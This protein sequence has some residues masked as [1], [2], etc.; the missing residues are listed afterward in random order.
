MPAD[1]DP[2][3][4]SAN[5]RWKPALGLLTGLLWLALAAAL[6]VIGAQADLARPNLASRD[7]LLLAGSIIVQVAAPL[8]VILV[9]LVLLRRTGRDEVALITALETR[10]A[11]AIAASNG[12]RNGLNEIDRGLTAI[13]ARLELLQSTANSEGAGLVDAATRLDAAATAMTTAGREA[14]QQAT[15]L[16]TLIPDAGKQA[17]AV[18][19]ILADTG[20]ETTRQVGEIETLLAAVWAR[21]TD[22]KAQAVDASTAMTT[23]LADLEGAAARTA[24]TVIERSAALHG[25]VDQ[26]FDRTTAA[27]DATRDGVHAQTNAL[28]ASVDQAR[29]ALDHIGGEAARAIGKRLDRLNEA[30][31][32]LGQRLSEQDA[33]SRMLV[34]TVERSFTVLDAKLNN[35]ANASNSTLD[36]IAERMS[37]VREQVHTLSE[38]LGGANDAM[39]EIETSAGRLQEVARWVLGAFGDQLPAHSEGLARLTDDAER[40]HGLTVRLADPVVQGQAAIAAAAAAFAQQRAE[41]EA[42]SSRVTAQLEAAR[43]MIGAIETQ[44]DGS[45]LAASNRLIEVLGRVREIAGTTSAQMRETLNAVVAE[46]EAALEHAGTTRAETAFGAPIREQLAAIADASDRAAEAAKGAADRVAERLL[47]LTATV[48]GVETRIDEVDTR[49]DMRRRDDLVARSTRLLESLNAGAIDIAKL[50]AVDVGDSTW[51]AYRKGDRSI[52]TRKVV[53]LVDAGTARA[54]KRHYAHDPEF[55]EQATRYIDDFETLMK[56]VIADR[57]GKMLGVTML[58]S[59]V[60]KLYVVLAEAIGRLE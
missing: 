57:D 35:A 37:A 54:V 4:P 60:G 6:L 40:L 17:T 41:M 38:P 44:T 29:V 1:P 50:L 30:A 49:F 18:A 23:L 11:R 13:G 25:S 58:S 9:S 52:F 42:A 33:R 7:L 14:G 27:L 53:R 39:T 28:L 19:A 24:A 59:D 46:A 51:D 48:A 10:Q 21:N 55:R 36:G 31:D 43:G 45:A 5:R 3:Q 56:H 12:L 22:A 15:A 20:A 34:E 16:M 8:A 47:G 2:L 32:Q 26:A